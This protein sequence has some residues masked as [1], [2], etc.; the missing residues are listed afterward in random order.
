MSET[1]AVDPATVATGSM[2]NRSTTE[3]PSSVIDSTALLAKAVDH[4]AAAQ[5]VARNVP[6]T[7][8]LREETRDKL[9]GIIGLKGRDT[10]F[11]TT[12]RETASAL[13]ALIHAGSTLEQRVNTLHRVAPTKLEFDRQVAELPWLDPKQTNAIINARVANDATPQSGLG[14][15]YQLSSTIYDGHRRFAR[16]S[17][18]SRLA[19][20]STR[21]TELL[22]EAGKAG[23]DSG[24]IDALSNCS[25]HQ[26]DG[27]LVLDRLEETVAQ[28]E[29]ALAGAHE[30]DF[31]PPT[32][33]NQHGL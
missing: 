22:D 31:A 33:S 2:A 32:R 19:V 21:R 14:P 26:L 10:S 5:S 15:E 13:G 30:T 4:W 8:Q 7:A 9:V 12:N 1:T 17:E 27:L 11:A 3:R 24:A 23:L 20:A 29:T 6:L 25:V 28:V 16:D 18:F